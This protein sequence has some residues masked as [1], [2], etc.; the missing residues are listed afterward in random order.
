[1]ELKSEYFDKAEKLI[2][3]KEIKAELEEAEKNYEDCL[4]EI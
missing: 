3:L 4:F 1:M 2:E